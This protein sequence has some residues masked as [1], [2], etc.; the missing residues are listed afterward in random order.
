MNG[1]LT[2]A[3]NRLMRHLY[4]NTWNSE[5]HLVD[6]GYADQIDELLAA[7]LVE[8]GTFD[9]VTILIVTPR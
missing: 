9:G 3:A 6:Q 8:R 2:N 4:D 7:G 5:Q 1:T